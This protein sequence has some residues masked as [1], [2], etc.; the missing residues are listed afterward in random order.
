VSDDWSTTIFINDK[1]HQCTGLNITFYADSLHLPCRRCSEH[2]LQPA[3][4][5]HLKS[6]GQVRTSGNVYS[7]KKY[8]HP[9]LNTDTQD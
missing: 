3:S 2:H 5:L 6:G 9:F 7:L 1:P 4:I 8:T